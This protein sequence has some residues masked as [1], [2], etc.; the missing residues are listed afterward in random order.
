MEVKDIVSLKMLFL[1]KKER[2]SESV[3]LIEKIQKEKKTLIKFDNLNKTLP[4]RVCHFDTKINAFY[5]I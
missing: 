4:K 2:I 5:L 3:L 1:H